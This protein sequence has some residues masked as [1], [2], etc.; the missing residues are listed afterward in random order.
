V[1]EGRLQERVLE[2]KKE[3][4]FKNLKIELGYNHA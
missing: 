1:P 4:N 3:E 2:E